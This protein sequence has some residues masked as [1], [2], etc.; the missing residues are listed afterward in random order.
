MTEQDASESVNYFLNMIAAADEPTKATTALTVRKQTSKS[1]SKMQQ[2]MMHHFFLK[3]ADEISCRQTSK[4]HLTREEQHYI[5]TLDLTQKHKADD[6]NVVVPLQSVMDDHFSV[7]SVPEVRCEHCNKLHTAGKQTI[8]K[9][10]S[11]L[12]LVSSKRFYCDDSAQKTKKLPT[13]VDFSQPIALNCANDQQ[14]HEVTAVINHHGQNFQH[15]HYTVYKN[16]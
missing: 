4:S 10:S 2:W 15:G 13:A 3:T 14:V 8:I 16:R 7:K 12:L 5:L 9:Q 1:I 6:A 11:E